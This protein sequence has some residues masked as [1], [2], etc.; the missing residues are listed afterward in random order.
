MKRSGFTLIELSIVL[1]IIGLIIGSVMKGK[2]LINSAEQKKIY[3]TWVKQWQVTINEYEDRT[4]ALLGDGKVN[5]GIAGTENGLFDNFYER[6]QGTVPTVLK[7][8]GLDLPVS[9]IASTKGGQYKIQGKYTIG[10]SDLYFRNNANVGNV[11]EFTN[12]PIDV[13]IAFD[14]MTDG[15][16]DRASGDFTIYPIPTPTASG[17][18][19]T[20]WGDASAGTTVNVALKL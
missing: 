15:T 2:D 9:N 16:I 13:A 20:P 4:G 14:K 1:I 6:T 11:L 7:N 19:A 18:A 17:A 8:T 12:I 5:G 3:N 10:R